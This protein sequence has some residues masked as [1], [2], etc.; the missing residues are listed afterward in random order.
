M[1][2]LTSVLFCLLAAVLVLSLCACGPQEAAEP[3]AELP[4][5]PSTMSAPPTTET[6][7]EPPTTEP[8]I[9]EP[10]N[11]GEWL[12]DGPVEP[13]VITAYSGT[14]IWPG[15]PSK[16][17]TFS[18][19][20]IVMPGPYIEEIN[21]EIKE[22]FYDDSVSY[23]YSRYESY[24]CGNY[25]TVIIYSHISATGDAAEEEY[26][27]YTIDIEKC[28]PATREEILEAAGV[29]EEEF[30]EKNIA[31][32]VKAYYDN[33][34][35]YDLSILGFDEAHVESATRDLANK[36]VEKTG[37][38][39]AFPFFG[40]DGSLWACGLTYQPAGQGSYFSLV[41]LE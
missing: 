37:Q 27:V 35:G 2:K 23:D 9:T 3:S 13:E 40:E 41:P 22:C 16:E 33:R 12:P 26:T 29:T 5:E 18:V 11:T 32:Q 8:Q 31:A 34:Y 14:A 7:T 28:R 24:V 25:L 36:N 21:R 30:L 38:P 6:P 19:P 10:E 4:T 17:C 15:K 1:K 39:L 20:R